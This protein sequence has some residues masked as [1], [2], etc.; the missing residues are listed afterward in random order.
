MERGHET[1]DYGRTGAVGNSRLKN[2]GRGRTGYTATA[3]ASKTSVK[4][5]AAATSWQ[6]A[7]WVVGDRHRH[8]HTQLLGDGVSSMLVDGSKII[9]KQIPAE[10]ARAAAISNQMIS[11]AVQIHF[12]LFS[13]IHTSAH[14]YRHYLRN[15]YTHRRILA[16]SK[17][18]A[19]ACRILFVYTHARTY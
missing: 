1:R 12:L 9:Q 15:R 19:R 7:V 16:H 8:T 10:I 4:T 5:K 17:L 14:I 13:I 2:C 18:C 6:L 3:A 11:K